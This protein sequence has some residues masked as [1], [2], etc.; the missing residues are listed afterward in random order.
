[1]GVAETLITTKA[2]DARQET[3]I[4]KGGQ[5]ELPLVTQQNI[6]RRYSC[7]DSQVTKSNKHR[8]IH[9]SSISKNQVGGNEY[10]RRLGTC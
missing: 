7:P 5:G 3:R 4:A 2:R 9:S 8:G 6:P 1:M 10:F